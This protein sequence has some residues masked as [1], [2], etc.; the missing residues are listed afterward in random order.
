MNIAAFI[1]MAGYGVSMVLYFIYL[2]AQR[3]IFYNAGRW[4]LFSGFLCHTFILG[5][6]VAS[7]GNIPAFTLGQ[8]LFVSGWALAAV[9]L[10]P[11][12]L[13]P[14]LAALYGLGYRPAQLARHGS[15][16]LDGALNILRG[17]QPGVDVYG[18]DGAATQSRRLSRGPLAAW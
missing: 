1:M 15:R 14:P 2:I 4:A 6:R 17:G 9:F 16:R 13:V 10:L 18:R 5:L 7:T 12:F 3:E 11:V 8:A